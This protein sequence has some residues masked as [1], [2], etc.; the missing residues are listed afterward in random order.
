L[1]LVDTHAPVGWAS[2]FAGSWDDHDP[3]P[4]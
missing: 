2:C 3:V 1:E 4:L